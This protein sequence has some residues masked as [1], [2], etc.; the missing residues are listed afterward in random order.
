MYYYIGIVAVLSILIGFA[1]VKDPASLQGISMAVFWGTILAIALCQA[2]KREV[3]GNWLVR[4]M[5]IGLFI[6]FGMAFMHLAVGFWFYG[7]QLDF[8]G[9]HLA[10][11]R[12]GRGLLQGSW[13]HTQL[14]KD[15]LGLFYIMA[16]PG[17]VGMFLLTGVI[18]FLGSYLFLRAFDLEFPSDGRRDKRFLA[19][20]LFLLPSLAYWAILL[21][22]DSWI[23]L[24]LGWASYAFANLLK[25]F[26]L[27]HFLGLLASVAAVTLIRLPVGAVLV[28]A[29]G[30][31]WLLKKGK[32]SPAGI[33]RPVRLVIYPMVIVG[34]AIV[35][36]S[37]Y[38]DQYKHLVAEA[39]LLGAALEVGLVK[40]AGLS[41]DAV[42]SGLAIGITE[43]SVWGFL[44]YLPIGIFTFLFRPLIFE[45]HH[46]LALAAALESTFFLALVFWRFRN[47]VAAVKSVFSR[48]FV[49]F[50]AI[51]FSL[52]TAMLSLES[53]FGVIVRHRTMVLPFLL[54]LLAVPRKNKRSGQ[55]AASPA[56]SNGEV[57]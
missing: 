52:L 4:V 51:T 29:V 32:S 9:Y 48:P 31:G 38:L 41:T 24:F 49:A 18:G 14:T 10:G 44:E 2:R 16:G 55:I 50:C 5:L 46:A 43:P 25:R 57:R 12:F 3:D 35:I 39:S 28:F 26:R 42:G 33:L 13:E 1:A 36:I 56:K 54:I 19:L 6:R 20:S 8:P 7:G 21:G 45:A 27:R 15:L 40:H 37:S 30:C 23:F 17:I 53:N 34:I 11:V 47:L 22:K